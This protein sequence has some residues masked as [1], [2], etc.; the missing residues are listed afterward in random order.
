MTRAEHEAEAVRLIEEARHTPSHEV[1]RRRLEAA[2]IHATLALAAA[3][4]AA[5]APVLTTPPGS[6]TRVK[7]A[8]P[9]GR[10]APA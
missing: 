8:D 4:E 10:G 1:A 7:D 6:P 5:H 9:L 2:Q 3:T